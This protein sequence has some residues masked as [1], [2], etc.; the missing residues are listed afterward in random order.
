MAAWYD[1]KV[2]QGYTVGKGG[3][4]DG[5]DFAT[6]IHTPLTS[7][8]SGQVTQHTGWYPWGGEVDIRLPNGL[9]ET[10]A[11]LDA[12][13]VRPGDY[14]Q[15]GQ[16]IG[17]SGGENLPRQYSTGPHTHVSL[18]G[19]APWDNTKSIDPTT[20]IKAAEPIVRGATPAFG[21][22][23]PNYVASLIPNFGIGTQVA[24]GQAAGQAAYNANVITNAVNFANQRLSQGATR[25]AIF[26]VGIALVI[27]ALLIL[28]WP[29]L[30]RGVKAG[31][32]AGATAAKVAAL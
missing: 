13:T 7:L 23:A 20:T 5:L 6:P 24:A 28:A 26:S 30:Q 8:Y 14:I 4:H 19:G 2:T 25:V 12:E 15:A 9:T 1:Y 27:L 10:F 16:L 29:T 17:Y 31:A 18:F 32:R 11:H 22:N 3:N 21:P